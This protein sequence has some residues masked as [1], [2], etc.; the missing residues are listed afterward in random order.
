MQQRTKN[1]MKTLVNTSKYKGVTKIYL[2]ESIGKKH[3]DEFAFFEFL[4]RQEFSIKENK[5]INWCKFSK[6]SIE[7]HSLE[8]DVIEF[9]DSILK[10]DIITNTGYYYKLINL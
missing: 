8:Y 3:N 2:F 10:N 6:L 4:V 7:V 5:S 1:N 9:V